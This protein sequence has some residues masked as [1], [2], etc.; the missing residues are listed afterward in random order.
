MKTRSSTKKTEV[1]AVKSGI[2]KSFKPPS[3]TMKEEIPT[4]A[5]EEEKEEA[6]NFKTKV[7]AVEQKIMIM[8]KK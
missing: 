4:T 7:E 5:E 1:D 6:E 8:A 2:T 3:S